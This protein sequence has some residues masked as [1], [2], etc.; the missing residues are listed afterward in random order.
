MTDDNVKIKFEYVGESSD[1]RTA[2]LLKEIERIAAK[3]LQITVEEGCNKG[4]NNI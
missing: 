4:K 3:Y 2:E 1:K